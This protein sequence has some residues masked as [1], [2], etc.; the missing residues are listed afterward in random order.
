MAISGIVPSGSTDDQSGPRFAQANSVLRNLVRKHY[1]VR[2]LHFFNTAKFVTCMS[3]VCEEL[4]PLSDVHFSDQ[5]HS[6]FAEKL[7]GFLMNEVPK[8]K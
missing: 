7:F 4:N 8:F 3:V 5:G 2:N 1:G 6:L